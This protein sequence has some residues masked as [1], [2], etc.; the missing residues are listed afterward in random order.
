MGVFLFQC[1]SSSSHI[2]HIYH[3]FLKSCSSMPSIELRKRMSL[4][5][6]LFS[7]LIILKGNDCFQK[8]GLRIMKGIFEMQHVKCLA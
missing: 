5:F 8:R 7:F 6:E 4:I 2:Y 1:L 3:M